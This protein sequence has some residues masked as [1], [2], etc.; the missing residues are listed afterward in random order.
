MGQ[1]T[2]IIV[3]HVDDENGEKTTSVFYNKWGIGRI[4]PSNFM[5]ILNATIGCQLL[6]QKGK[7]LI[8]Q[9]CIDIT[10]EYDEKERKI[11]DSLDFSKPK[12]VG[13]IVKRAANNNGA[14]FV[15]I[16]AKGSNIKSIEYAY[17]LGEEEHGDYKKFCTEKEWMDKF[18]KYIDDDFRKLYDD[19]LRYFGAKE[20][21]NQTGKQQKQTAS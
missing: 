17:M 16:T 7:E 9:G 13:E 21:C 20:V 10:E 18:S 11:F 15:R 12:K 2:T 3:Q 4:M 8:P 5:S 14:I 19:T 6:N 1:R